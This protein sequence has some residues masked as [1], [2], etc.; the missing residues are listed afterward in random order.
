MA[1]SDAGALA[2]ADWDVLSGA[3][4]PIITFIED[5][6]IGP[7]AD[8]PALQG[9]HNLQNARAAAA[10]CSALGL[11]DAEI[12]AGLA[13]YPGLAHRMEPVA[14]KSGV[15]YVND[16][17]ATN[18]ESA[19]PAL[20]A[21]PRTHWIAGGRAKGAD[22]GALVPHLGALV[23]AYLVGEAAPVFAPILS[24]H[25]PVV[26]AGTLDRAVAAAA[27][28]AQPGDTVLLSPACASFDQFTDFE[29][30]GNAFRSLVEAL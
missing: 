13:S 1:A 23:A 10:A 15:R 21:F 22:L 6:D 17:K 8:W 7:Q 4:D 28:A 5:V 24:P 16:S 19:A 27:A 26:M 2:E 18:P 9:L 25:V 11:S 29:A 14:T 3:E 30:R 12:V 20:T